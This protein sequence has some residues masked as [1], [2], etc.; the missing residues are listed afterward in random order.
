MYIGSL[1]LLN[2]L[3]LLFLT[4]GVGYFAYIQS[5][6]PLNF[7]GWIGFLLPILGT[8]T[9]FGLGIIFR[10]IEEGEEE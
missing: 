10:D 6:T 8:L 4:V 7:G 2:L 3:T 5:F 1:R 9:A